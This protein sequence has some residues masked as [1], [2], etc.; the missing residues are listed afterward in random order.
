VRSGKTLNLQ[1][2]LVAHD[3]AVFSQEHS[4]LL[5]S[6][7]QLRVNQ[8]AWLELPEA[9]RKDLA[10][11][12]QS[13]M[14]ELNQAVVCH[15]K[16]A[17]ALGMERGQIT[18][19]GGRDAGIYVGQRM[20]ILPKGTTLRVRGL[21]QSLGVVGLAEVVRVGPRTSSLEVYAGPRHT[22]L[23]DMTAIPVSA[24]SL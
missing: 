11:W 19:V 14:V 10:I 3:G 21:Q 1:L 24:L 2:S 15:A 8:L 20:A 6:S 7:R 18:L 4:V 9:A 17:L 23:A 5:D 22:D 16:S 12:I 13:A